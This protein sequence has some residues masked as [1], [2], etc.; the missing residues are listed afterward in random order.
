MGFPP[1]VKHELQIFDS[2]PAANETTFNAG[3]PGLNTEN[4]A[5]S[6][7]LYSPNLQIVASL[8]NT[9]S[10]V[11]STYTT[12]ITQGFTFSTTQSVSITESVGV[13]IEV[14]TASVSTTFALSFTEQW[15]T[16][17]TKTMSFSCPPGKKAFVYQGTLM[18][19][20]LKFDSGSNTYTWSGE[21]AKALTQVLVTSD[22]PIGIAPSSQVT[23]NR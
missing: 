20:S 5:V 18:S 22:T 23:I 8:D 10:S 12:S 17:T 21:A 16:S 2:L 1:P 3:I 9:N 13:S 15:S 6:I 7:I 4:V 14:V 19:Q 11:T